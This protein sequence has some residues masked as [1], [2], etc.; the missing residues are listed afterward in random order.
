M[1]DLPEVP[2]ALVLSNVLE[3]RAGYVCCSPERMRGCGTAEDR[4]GAAGDASWRLNKQQQRLTTSC[5]T[6]T[7]E[8]SATVVVE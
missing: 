3:T 2:P 1:V 4:Q 5:E 8:E 6:C 7:H